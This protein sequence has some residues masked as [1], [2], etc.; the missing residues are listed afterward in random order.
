MVP[1][2]CATVCTD[3]FDEGIH[4]IQERLEKLLSL[5]GCGA[6]VETHGLQTGR[7]DLSVCHGTCVSIMVS[8]LWHGFLELKCKL[9]DVEQQLG[10]QKE[11]KKEIKNERKIR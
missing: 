5:V 8:Y 10:S 2:R 4:G 11:R 1:L 9:P 3:L 7:A 6:I